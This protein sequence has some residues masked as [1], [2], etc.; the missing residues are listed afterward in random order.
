M[1]TIAPTSAQPRDSETCSTSAHDGAAS[2][3]AQST[4]HS[5]RPRFEATSLQPHLSSLLSSRLRS[6]RWDKCDKENNRALSRCIA[7][8]I[9][10]KMLEVQAKGACPLPFY[11]D[12]VVANKQADGNKDKR[13]AHLRGDTGFKY[14]VQVQLVENLGQGGSR[15]GLPLGRLG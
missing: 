2:P 11:I 13:N 12:T 1:S 7:E 4:S 8:N 10:A 15:P 6:A 14:I 3:V 9:K 5:T